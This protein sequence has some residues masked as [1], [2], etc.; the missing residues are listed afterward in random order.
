MYAFKFSIFTPV[1]N[2][3][4]TIHR[5]Y[6]SLR[7]STYK[8]FEWIVINDGS[9][10]NSEEIIRAYIKD[11]DWDIIFV[12]RSVNRGKHIS[13]N[14]AVKLAKGEVFIVIDCD[15]AFESDSL[16]YLNNKW[17]YYYKDARI[18][19]IN[20]LCKDPR[21]NSVVGVK[22]PYDGIVSNYNELYNK[23]KCR[24]DKWETYRTEYIKMFPFPEVK[25]H[26]YT[27][28]YLLYLI[29]EKYKSVGYNK[30]LRHYYQE[31]NSIT[32]KK[33]EN[34]DNLYMIAHYQKWHIPRVV[35]YLWF[36][37]PRELFRCVKELI[38]VTLKYNIMRILNIVEI[39][40]SK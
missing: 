8:N 27:E 3:A 37:Y 4:K 2:G 18:A 5:V 25:A 26:Y 13:W 28:C 22:F 35:S 23:Y 36:N 14:E 12:N 39:S 24:G 17:N 11:V 20:V 34:I 16:S 33:I 31:E 38:I 1:Y 19:C 15:D 32:H 7:N 10:D 30:I 9:V 6:N 40:Y 29:G 21:N